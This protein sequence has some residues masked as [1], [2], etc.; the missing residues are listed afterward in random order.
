MPPTD[1]PSVSLLQKSPSSPIT[2]HAT[3]F[4]PKGAVLFWRKDGEE[5]Y[6][7]VEHGEILPNQ[8]GSFQM[9]VELLKLPPE[10][11]GKYECVFLLSGVKEEIITKLQKQIIRTNYSESVLW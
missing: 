6:E 10:D 2:C 1:L 7:D 8:D 11:W 9:S 5:L 3:G 4:F